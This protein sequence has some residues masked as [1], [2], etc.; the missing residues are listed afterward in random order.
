M[1]DLVPG[2]YLFIE[3]GLLQAADNESE[4][5]GV[6]AHEIAH[7]TARH[8]AKMMK[9]ATIASLFYQAAQIAA[10]IL[11][12]GMAGIAGSVMVLYA[13]ILGPVIPDAFGHILVA[14]VLGAP[15]IG[16]T[17]AVYPVPQELKATLLLAL[18]QRGAEAAHR[19]LGR[20]RAGAAGGHHRAGS[21]RYKGG[22]R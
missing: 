17:Q 8:S 9:R 15:A 1:R 12:G 5:A 19:L 16:I 7:D 6:I 10:A 14:A 4:L 22:P 20:G 13:A 11:T 18:L 2:G 21:P 3:R